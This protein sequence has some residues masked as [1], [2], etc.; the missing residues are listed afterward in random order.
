MATLY[1]FRGLPGSGKTTAAGKLAAELKCEHFEADQFFMVNGSY[2]FNAKLLHMAHYECFVNFVNEIFAGRD[3]VI[4]NTFTKYKEMQDY[5]ESAIL[6]GANIIITECTG[7]YGSIHDIPQHSIDRMAGRW[8]P[9]SD[10]R[11]MMTGKYGH[12]V[13]VK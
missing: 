9:Q 3:V 2:R 1:I 11:A 10:L 7:N 4:S 6:H 8:L 5:I 13:I 12:R